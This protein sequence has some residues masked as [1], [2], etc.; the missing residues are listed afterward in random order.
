MV[1]HRILI[2]YILGKLKVLNS[3]INMR[4][5]FVYILLTYSK[6][7]ISNSNTLHFRQQFEFWIRIFLFSILTGY[8]LFVKKVLLYHLLF[9]AVFYLNF[10]SSYGWEC[11]LI[12]LRCDWD[13][14]LNSY[15]Q[16]TSPLTSTKTNTLSRGV[17]I[18]IVYA[19]SH[20][21]RLKFNF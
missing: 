1:M 9:Y 3:K 12:I 2:L 16:L 15:K 6:L 8:S 10:L 11:I 21:N 13:K 20:F 17:C 7:I 4:L 18:C 19:L 14:K 5:G